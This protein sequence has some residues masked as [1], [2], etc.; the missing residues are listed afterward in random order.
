M[1][2]PLD[3]GQVGK[4]LAELSDRIVEALARDNLLWGS[5][6]FRPDIGSHCSRCLLPVSCSIRYSSPS[7]LG[8]GQG[9]AT[10]SDVQQ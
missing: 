4:F 10:C 1:T 2:K 5:E 8:T 3:G 7:S 9:A 6:L